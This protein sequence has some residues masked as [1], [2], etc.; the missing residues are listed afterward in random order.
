M[1]RLQAE[2]QRLYLS[3][4]AGADAA[5]PAGLALTGP[6][7]QVRSL[8]LELAGPSS[9]ERL[10]KIWEDVQV[11][12]DFPAPG[13][14]VSGIDGYQLWFSLAEPVPAAQARDM[15]SALR[16]RYLGDVA[17]ERVRMSPAG[18]TPTIR[19]VPPTEAAPGQWS[20]FVA[21]DLATLF[22]EEPWLDLPPSPDAQ[23][24]LLSRLRSVPPADFQ[25]ALARLASAEAATD[26]AM[27]LSGTEAGVAKTLS[28]QQDPRRFL[29]EVMNDPAV[30]LRLRIE[31]AKALL[32]GFEGQRPL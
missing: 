7:G 10:N 6:D 11:E 9:W 20:A 32:P 31:A 23:A 5:E 15:L 26:S 14:A 8:V 4:S 17:P 29:L 18:A 24:D 28:F 13:I 12:L 25:R 3:P 27:T 22:V 21:P 2:L 1:N 19:G 16:Q 30:E